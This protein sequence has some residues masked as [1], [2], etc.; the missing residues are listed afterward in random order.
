MECFMGFWQ[1][2][3][4]IIDFIPDVIQSMFGER[5]HLSMYAVFLN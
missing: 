1:L 3:L 2:K 5:K 4:E